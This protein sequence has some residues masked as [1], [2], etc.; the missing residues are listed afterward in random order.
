RGGR[1]RGAL[2]RKRALVR[3]HRAAARSRRGS[4]VTD[5]AG[6]TVLVTG[7]SRGI[8]AAA[9]AALGAAGA[10]VV[11]HYGSYR[12]GAEEAVA[13]LP[14]ERR[15][16][17]QADF[18]VAGSARALWQRVLEQ[19]PRV[20][21]LV[22]NAAVSVETPFDGP[23]EPWD[24]G[25]AEVLRVNLIEPPTGLRGALAPFRG[26]GAGVITPLPSWA[27]QQGSA[28]APPPA[29]AASKAAIKAV[30]QTVARNYA[31]E[32]VLAYVV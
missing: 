14:P 21:A 16:L 4:P 11:A 15:T 29:Y 6:R 17:L 27:A 25:W 30:T 10:T 20:D 31:K 3:H 22:V 18:N 13:G 8:G 19:R 23:A 9:A 2:P 1:R 32:G 28:I 26:Q 7:A 5:L 12:E 24:E